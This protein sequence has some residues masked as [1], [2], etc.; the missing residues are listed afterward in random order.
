M[1]A[2]IGKS[3][4]AAAGATWVNALVVGV[5]AIRHGTQL[6][7]LWGGSTEHFLDGV[8]VAAELYRW[9][10]EHQPGGAW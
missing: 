10:A 6:L 1:V 8:G 5:R 9:V 7:E 2:E 3:L 4:Q